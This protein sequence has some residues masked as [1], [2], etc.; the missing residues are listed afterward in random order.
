MAAQADKGSIKL[1]GPKL[2]P[3]RATG[4]LEPIQQPWA[5][6]ALKGL[7][8]KEEPPGGRRSVR[9]ANHR[10]GLSHVP[11]AASITRISRQKVGWVKQTEILVGLRSRQLGLFFHRA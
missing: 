1:D 8:P 7:L 3:L 11:A 10:P 5:H 9:S 4:P 2:C 6:E